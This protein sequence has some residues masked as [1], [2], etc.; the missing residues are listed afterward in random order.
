MQSNVNVESP[1]FAVVIPTYNRASLITETINS[2]LN[3]KFFDFELIIVDD[4]STDDTEAV[5]ASFKDKR[6]K[7]IKKLN[8]ER[9]AARNY[10]ILHSS[11]Q[12]VTFCDSDDL[13][14][15][16]Y[17][18]NAY[19][20]ICKY[21]SEVPW[22]HLSYEK[23][24]SD[25]KALKMSIDPSNYIVS[26]AKGNPL[27]CMG[28]FVKRD[29]IVKNLFNEDRYLAGSEDWELWIRLASKYP[30]VIDNRVSASL[31]LHDGRSVLASD[32]LKLQ[33]RKFLSIGYA[34]D[35]ESVKV[36]FSN[37]KKLME[38][39]FDTYISL[40]L[41]LSGKTTSSFRYLLKAILNYPACVFD[42][43]FLAIVKY[44]L[45]NLKNKI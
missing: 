23:K 33:L 20:T 27:S 29:V 6:I 28:V 24:R 11:S 18:Q 8:Q 4:G 9:G 5:V 32:E 21:K 12:Y 10:G 2:V 16:D 7:F 37:Y 14:Y 45:I 34:F 41:M 39:Y 17:L 44:W 13:L 38:A 15:S 35:D 40:H 31:L 19:E 3:Q 42:R 25:G 1:F 22:L 36:V 43:R 26:L 30:I